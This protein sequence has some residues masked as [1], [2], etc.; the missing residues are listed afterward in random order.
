MPSELPPDSPSLSPNA[1]PLGQA[2]ARLDAQTDDTTLRLAYYE[3]LSAAEVFVLLRAEPMGDGPLDPQLFPLDGVETVLAFDSEP[4]LAAFAGRAV[5]YAALPGRV[6]V[7]LLAQASPPLALLVQ[8][9]AGHGDLMSPDALAWLAAT[10]AAPAPR[11]GQGRPAGYGPPDLPAPVQAALVPALER[12]LSGIP[13]LTDAILAAVAWDTGARGHLLALAGVPEGAQAPLAR[14][15]AEALALSG[16]E[17]GSLD[18]VYP[19]PAALAPIVAA[20]LRLSPAPF[21][22]ATPPVPGSPGSDPTRPPRLR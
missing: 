1:T 2:L 3:V 6:L 7:G 11:A 18:V 19:P 12:R 10:L 21:V 9:G 22:P 16:A 14:A 4:A 15:V 13:G 17:A 5:P 20:G 8:D